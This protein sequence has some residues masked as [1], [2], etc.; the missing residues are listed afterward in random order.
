MGWGRDE[1]IVE[2][3]DSKGK[4][5]KEQMGSIR[6]SHTDAK[7]EIK[8]SLQSKDLMIFLKIQE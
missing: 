6:I 8:L 1:D 7:E 5:S 4:D 2:K 3:R